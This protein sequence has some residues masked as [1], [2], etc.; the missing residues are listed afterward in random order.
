MKDFFD[1]KV[2]DESKE[3]FEEFKNRDGKLLLLLEGV[4]EEALNR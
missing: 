1:W 3:K 2:P 4:I